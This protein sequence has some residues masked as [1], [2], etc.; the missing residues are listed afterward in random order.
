MLINEV[1]TSFCDGERAKQSAFF[2]KHVKHF[3]QAYSSLNVMR[4]QQEKFSGKN[5]CRTALG[6][7]HT[8]EQS[9]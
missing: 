6:R 8:L 5:L 7:Q 3:Q 9:R 1:E 2:C 4:F